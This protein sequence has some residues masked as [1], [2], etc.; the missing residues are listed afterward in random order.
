MSHTVDPTQ[1]MLIHKANQIV[2]HDA[3]IRHRF[4]LAAGPQG[5]MLHRQDT[6]TGRERLE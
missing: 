1:F 2:P 3:P 4:R 6:E 5:A